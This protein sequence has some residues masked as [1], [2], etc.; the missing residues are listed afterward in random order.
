M[1]DTHPAIIDREMWELARREEKRR[2]EVKERSVGAGR[3]SSKYALSGLLTCAHCGHAMRRQVRTVGSGKKIPSWGCTYRLQNG[4]HY[5]VESRNV[6]EDVL[7]E[8][9]L[10]SLNEIAGNIDDYLRIIRQ[11]CTFVMTPKKQKEIADVEQDIIDVQEKVLDLHKQKREGLL[12]PSAFNQKIAAQ[13]E[14]MERLQEKQQKLYDEQGNTLAV[15]HWLNQFQ[16]ATDRMDEAAVDTTVIKTLVNKMVVDCSREVVDIHF[17]CGVI[18][19][20]TIR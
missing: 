1:E 8:A 5:C 18:I 16:D 11:N 10:K 2:N 4:R 13:K 7:L 12:S 17:K 19:T 6:R 3:Y 15:E 9:Y 14:K 20:E